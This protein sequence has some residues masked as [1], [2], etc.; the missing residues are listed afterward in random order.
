MGVSR[1][2][3]GHRQLRGACA[4][5]G[6]SGF[7]QIRCR[8]HAFGVM[9]EDVG[10]QGGGKLDGLFPSPSALF[11]MFVLVMSSFVLGHFEVSRCQQLFVLLLP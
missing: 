5:V 2:A 3:E 7:K 11:R 9:L 10:F 1:A 4:S 8:I 6:A